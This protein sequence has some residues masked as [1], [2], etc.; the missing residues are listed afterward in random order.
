MEKVAGEFSLICTVHN[1]KKIARAM[2]RGVVRLECG[3]L[4]ENQGI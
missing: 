4:V 1:L 2:I 3:K